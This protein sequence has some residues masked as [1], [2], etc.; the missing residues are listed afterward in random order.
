MRG[1]KKLAS[2]SDEDLMALVAEKDAAAFEL[3]YERHGR[4][5]FSLAYRIL[6]DRGQ[7]EDVTQETFLSTWRSNAAF[8]PARGSV[9]TW[10]LGVV[11]NRAIDL[12]RR[13]SAKRS[14]RLELRSD[15]AIEETS[16]AASTEEEAMRRET[17]REVR[18]V[19]DGLPPAQ[20]QVVQ[21]AY[22]GGFS[23]SEIAN[24]LG[25]PVGTVKGRM[26]LALTKVRSGLAEQVS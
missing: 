26:R 2:L 16:S 9:R 12:V 5:A 13:E 3:F 4:A 21:L 10:I 6:G 22:F 8:D 7:A 23:Q 15:E 24:V 25:L 17:Q 14:P 1:R 19:L 11:R 18:T 20:A